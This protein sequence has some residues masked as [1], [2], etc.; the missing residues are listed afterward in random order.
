T[1]AAKKQDEDVSGLLIP[2][3]SEGKLKDIAWSLGVNES[4][5]AGEEKKKGVR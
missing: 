1:E 5:Y 4:I 3:V 2:R